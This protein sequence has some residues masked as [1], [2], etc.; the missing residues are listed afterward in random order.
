MPVAATPFTSHLRGWAKRDEVAVCVYVC[1]C[2]C[3]RGC[4]LSPQLNPH[5]AA[6]SSSLRSAGEL[7]NHMEELTLF[8]RTLLQDPASKILLQALQVQTYCHMK[9]GSSM[10]GTQFQHFDFPVWPHLVVGLRISM[11]QH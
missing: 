9:R 3:G 4:V 2:V 6:D 1:V 7:A 8:L 5:Q 11:E 10:K